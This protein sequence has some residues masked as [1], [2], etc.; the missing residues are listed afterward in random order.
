MSVVFTNNATSTLA[1]AVSTT[2]QTTITVQSAD[3]NKFPFPAG[4]DWFPVTLAE[5]TKLEICKC[6]AHSGAVLT[7]V[8]G[9]EGTAA[10]TFSIGAAVDHRLT[11]VALQTLLQDPPFDNKVYARRNPN[12]DEVPADMNVAAYTFNSAIVAPAGMSEVR[13]NNADVTLVTKLWVSDIASNGQLGINVG[14]FYRNTIGAGTLVVVYKST[15]TDYALYRVTAVSGPLS[16]FYTEYTVTYVAKLG[17]FA[18]SDRV[19]FTT[20]GGG[21]G[22]SGI[23]LVDVGDTAPG[24]P[25]DRQLFWQ[26]NT[27]I[28]WLR[29]NDGSSTQ[30]VQVNG[31]TGGG[32]G[33]SADSPVFTGDPRAP[34]PPLADSDSSLAT[35]AFVKA[36]GLSRVSGLVIPYYLYPNN[37]YTDTNARHLLDLLRKYHAVPVLVVVNP[38]DGPGTVLDGN[39]AAFIK[40]LKA[41]GAK[42]CGYISTAYAA[43]PEADVKADVDRWLSVYGTTK[44]DGIF[45]DE[46]TWDTGPGNS[47]SA[48]VDLYK[49]YTDYCHDRHLYPVIANP[50]TNQQGAYFAT[51]TAD[52]IL[53]HENTNWPP[54][55]DM[56]GNYI[57]GHVEYSY[58]RRG[59][60]VYNQATLNTAQLAILRKNVQWVYSTDDNLTGGVLNPWDSLPTYLDQLFAA[61]A[62]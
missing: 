12:W 37:P 1:V 24:A 62:S 46:Q 48:Y 28:L 25:V 26:S 60:L 15:Y 61:V 53:V 38:A 50:G 31:A 16:P 27:G 23:G 54:E 56:E 6:T 3:A 58:T 19:W 11:K 51:W 55:A 18:N 49:R 8:R 33:I 32:G 21:G 43:R 20:V 42:V 30:W 7:V 52:V 9:Q 45:F 4:G 47:G 35:T 5:G 40:L 14:A 29:Y 44:P 17:A 2:G 34:N 22:G 59:A 41:A 13:L 39:W 57:G 36:V 10:Q